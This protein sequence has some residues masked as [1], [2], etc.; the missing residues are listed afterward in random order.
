MRLTCIWVQRQQ[1]QWDEFLR[2]VIKGHRS[3]VLRQRMLP[4]SVIDSLVIAWHELD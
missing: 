4:S 2:F 3:S 1:K